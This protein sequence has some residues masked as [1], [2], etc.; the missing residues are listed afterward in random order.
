MDLAF[1]SAAC[2]VADVMRQT[3]PDSEILQGTFAI[4][5]CILFSNSGLI[6]LMMWSVKLI[7]WKQ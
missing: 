3:F 6:I 4:A 2:V 5:S 7:L 1:F